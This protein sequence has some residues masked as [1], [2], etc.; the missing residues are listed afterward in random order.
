[1]QYGSC[2]NAHTNQ[3]ETVYKLSVPL[4]PK[5]E[6]K[7]DDVAHDF[8]NEVPSSTESAAERQG[9]LS[10][11]I[12]VLNE[13]ATGMRISDEDVE[14]ERRVIEEEW[15]GKNGVS[16]R[17]LHKYWD[18][19]F[20]KGG[21][22]LIAERF[23]IGLPE[24]F[25]KCDPQLIRDFYRKWY[26]PELMA[27][28]VVGDFDQDEQEHVLEAIRSTFGCM[29]NGS[30]EGAPLPIVELPRHPNDLVLVLE[31]AEL[32]QTSVSLEFFEKLSVANTLSHLRSDV[33]KRLFTTL[34]DQRLGA[35]S[36]Q[37]D[38]DKAGP[39]LGAGIACR[40]VVPDLN[41]TTI[42]AICKDDSTSIARALEALLE[43][44]S[45]GRSGWSSARRGRA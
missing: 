23:P 29:T 9:R 18:A 44:V 31:D 12:N 24:V 38:G 42:N 33:I 21:A 25:M 26:R 40:P 34:V 35:I 1:M 3:E 13:W 7:V 10:M 32:T 27:V 14:T 8:A 36:R 20:A 17:I 2:L 6:A 5:S 15:R 16:R 30:A 43:E 28:V 37:C 19:V 4:P 41:C 11:A 22:G 39:F 45:L